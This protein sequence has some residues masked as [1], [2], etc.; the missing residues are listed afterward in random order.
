METPEV[1]EAVWH[2]LGGKSAVELA[3]KRLVASMPEHLQAHMQRAIERDLGYIE[4]TERN[5]I[6]RRLEIASLRDPRIDSAELRHGLNWAAS[7]LVRYFSRPDKDLYGDI[8]D[9]ND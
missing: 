3:C 8:Y 5:K 6:A 4:Q 2:I 7:T 9:E 1:Q